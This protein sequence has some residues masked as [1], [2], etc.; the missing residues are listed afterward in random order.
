MLSVVFIYFYC[1][2]LV[3]LCIQW[4]Q[5]TLDTAGVKKW[6]TLAAKGTEMKFHVK[7]ICGQSN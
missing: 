3:T 1:H 6:E 2:C 5:E 4:Q 7:K